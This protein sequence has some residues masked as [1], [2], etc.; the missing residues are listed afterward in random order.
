MLNLPKKAQLGKIA[1]GSFN[2]YLQS[3]QPQEK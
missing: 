1:P 3:I 2:A